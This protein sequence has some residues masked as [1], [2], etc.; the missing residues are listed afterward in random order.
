MNLK[1]ALIVAGIVLAL[2]DVA[3]VVA[4]VMARRGG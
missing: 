4:V 2:L 1:K 3:L